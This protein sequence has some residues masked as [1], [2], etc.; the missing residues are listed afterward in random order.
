MTNT[1][2]SKND[3]IKIT[4]LVNNIMPGTLKPEHGFSLWI[5][6]CGNNILFD[7]GQSDILL[8]N[9]A[10]LGIDL[11]KTDIIILSHGHYDHTGGLSKVIQIAPDAKI[12]LHPQALKNR[13]SCHTDKPV[14]NIS[15]PKDTADFIS[16]NS[17]RV[18]F[19]TSSQ[20]LLGNFYITGEIPR[21]TSFEDT[22]GP[23]YLDPDKHTKDHIEDDLA[24]FFTTAN[25]LIVIVGCAHSGIINTLDHICKIS[26]QKNIYSVIGGM[27]LSKA[28]PDRMDQTIE[29]LNSRSIQQLYP[30]HCTGTHAALQIK[31]NFKND[32]FI[33]TSELAEMTFEI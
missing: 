9:A 26:G 11:S 29:S 16:A 8:D 5:E 3:N 18:K 2:S 30:M 21:I 4:P 25:G 14:K 27:H 23:F 17:S 15:M 24:V 19:I 6:Y 28:N 32:C 22:G 1:N 10:Q 33:E 20:N 31:Q 13:Y 12:Y 7:T